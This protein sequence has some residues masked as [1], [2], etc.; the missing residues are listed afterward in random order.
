MRECCRFPPTEPARS[1]A[2]DALQRQIADLKRAMYHLLWRKTGFGEKCVLCDHAF[3]GHD[4][5]CQGKEIEALI[6]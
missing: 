6:R 4:A 3:P 2:H 1:G 5:S